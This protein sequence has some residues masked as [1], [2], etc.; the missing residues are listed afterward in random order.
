MIATRI[1]TRPAQATTR[2]PGRPGDLVKFTVDDALAMVRLRI[3]PED[4]SVELL[5]GVLE[6]V[7]RRDH[8]SDADVGVG[9]VRFTVGELI[10][11]VDAG[12]LPEDASIE[13]LR[14]RLVYRDARDSERDVGEGLKH[15]LVSALLGKLAAKLD[16]DQRH[17]STQSA[18]VCGDTYM[19]VPDAAIFRGGPRDYT[20]RY[21]SPEDVYA[22]IEIS[23]T[24]YRKDV[25][26]KL[27]D[28]ARVGIRQYVILNLNNRTAEVYSDPD[29]AAGTY[30]T[31]ATIAADGTLPL[32][33]GDETFDVPLAELLP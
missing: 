27:S 14:G 16:T 21:P 15:R 33:V 12:I 5:D 20:E 9:P 32:R 30:R 18:I 2:Q 10:T 23:V 7:D 13:L 1:N 25:G 19:P 17:L 22:P 4:S 26:A 3:L 11:M 28:Y 24:T 29:V 31:K 8:G 6:Y